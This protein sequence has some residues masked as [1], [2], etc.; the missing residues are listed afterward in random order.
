MSDFLMAALA[1]AVVAGA[2]AG[3]G[4]APDS[5]LQGL[6]VAEGVSQAAC[7]IGPGGEGVLAVDRDGFSVTETA[8]RFGGKAPAGFSAVGGRMYCSSEG[9]TFP[10]QVAMARQGN[11]AGLSF[12][13]GAMTVFRRC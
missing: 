10:A 12:D 9:E 3:D 7:R 6:W 1:A 13:G 8:C 2:N 5:G 4:S 11:L